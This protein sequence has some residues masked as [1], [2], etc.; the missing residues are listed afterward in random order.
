MEARGVT[1]VPDIEVILLRQLASCLGTPIFLV[2]PVGTLVYYNEPAELILGRR[3][4][5]VGELTKEELAV[6]FKPTDG[7]GNPL[8]F[9]EVPVIRAL[10]ARSPAHREFWIESADGVRRRIEG[11]AFPIIG[12]TRELLGAVSIF[13]EK[14][15]GA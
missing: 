6:T 4:D 10:I 3:F 14:T 15:D 7:D 13:W 12:M 8:P 9:E 11:T 2:D 1:S 5:E